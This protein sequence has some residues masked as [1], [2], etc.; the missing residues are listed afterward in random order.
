MQL[1][2]L[3]LLDALV[4]QERATRAASVFD[5]IRVIVHVHACMDV[6]HPRTLYVHVCHGPT[7]DRDTLF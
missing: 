1:H 5:E 3:V 6:L 7:S 4:I 2:T